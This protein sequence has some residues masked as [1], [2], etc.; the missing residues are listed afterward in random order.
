MQTGIIK[1]NRSSI[2]IFIMRIAD[3]FGCRSV[4]HK[5][6][7]IFSVIGQDDDY[8]D[9]FE[10]Q[11]IGWPTD[12]LKRMYNQYAH[13]LEELRLN[14]PAKKRRRTDEYRSWYSRTQDCLY[15]MKLL[16][17]EIRSRQSYL[18]F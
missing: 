10:Q 1:R 6:D 9:L 8:W 18:E 17:L 15:A 2:L 3:G 5:Y 11:M 4:Y 12:E 7:S 16:E 13:V 14:E